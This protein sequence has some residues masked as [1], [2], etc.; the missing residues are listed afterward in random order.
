MRMTI[1]KNSAGTV[2]SSDGHQTVETRIVTPTMMLPAIAP[3]AV[4]SPP[5]VTEANTRSRS[6]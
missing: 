1:I 4:P 3:N 6:C 5:S 2:W